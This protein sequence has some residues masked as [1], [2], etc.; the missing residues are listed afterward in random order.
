[1]SRFRRVATEKVL[2]ASWVRLMRHTVEDSEG[3]ASGRAVMTLEG[4]DWVNVIARTQEGA[5]VFVRQHRFGT[6]QDSLEIPGGVID[7]GEEPLQAARRELREETGYEASAWRSMGWCFPNPAIQANR[8]HTFVAEGCTR[9]GEPELDE[10]EDC[11]VELIP[12]RELP[13]RIA[14]REIDHALVLVALL[15]YLGAQR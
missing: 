15:E 5:I 7:P 12:E 13:T 14:R 6:Q 3:R 8:V 10:L 2:E 11:R 4:A 9:A 1:M